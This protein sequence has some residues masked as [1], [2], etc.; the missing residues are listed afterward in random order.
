MQCNRGAHV[1]HVHQKVHVIW[2]SYGG[3]MITGY[4]VPLRMQHS[5]PSIPELTVILEDL[6][7]YTFQLNPV[8]LQYCRPPV[9]SH[10]T[11]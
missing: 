11:H 4:G 8:E 7:S 5:R 9:T 6:R 1:G 10:L 3:H 2:T